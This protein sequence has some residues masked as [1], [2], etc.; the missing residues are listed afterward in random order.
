MAPGWAEAASTVQALIQES[1]GPGRAH[2]S[3][4]LRE[5]AGAPWGGVKA[6]CHQL[7]CPADPI[8]VGPR[9]C[10][11]RFGA[12]PCA[13]WEGYA[14]ATAAPHGHDKRII[15]LPWLRARTRPAIH[16]TL[17]QAAS[18]RAA[19]SCSRRRPARGN[20]R[21]DWSL[22]EALPRSTRSLSGARQTLPAS[23]ASE[24]SLFDAHP[25]VRQ[26]PA[27]LV[28]AASTTPLLEGQGSVG[29]GP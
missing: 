2:P 29:P 9:I 26:T 11:C 13:P 18:P 5:L 21:T 14:H 3:R 24:P 19:A 28:S 17:C 6:T 7:L 8:A 4:G 27:H 10:R 20:R 1:T 16:L 22:R 23:S 15:R 25:P 12:A